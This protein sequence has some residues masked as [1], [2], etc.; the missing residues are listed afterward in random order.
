M[1]PPVPLCRSVDP[2]PSQGELRDRT[3][4][5]DSSSDRCSSDAVCKGLSD[6]TVLPQPSLP[7]QKH[8]HPWPRLGRDDSCCGTT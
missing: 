2:S 1:N 3:A 5:R 7:R 8:P 4:L 6:S